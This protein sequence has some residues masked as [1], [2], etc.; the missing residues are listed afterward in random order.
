MSKHKAGRPS[1]GRYADFLV[2]D[3]RR[4][5]DALELGRDWREGE[6][7]Y[8]V[9]WYEA[10][11]ELTAE[12]IDPAAEPALDDFHAG[13]VGPVEVLGRFATRE[14]LDLALGEWPNV[15]PSAPRTLAWLRQFPL[16]HDCPAAPA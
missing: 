10:T 12:R 9:C 14:A 13:V 1:Y 5:G 16:E 3:Q 11:G 6:H 2:D 8:R 4:R 15:L 7:I